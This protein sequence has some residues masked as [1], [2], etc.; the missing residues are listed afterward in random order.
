MIV[1]NVKE[2]RDFEAHTMKSLG[3]SELE[4]MNRAGYYLAKDFIKRVKPIKKSIISVF[5]G[6]GNNGGDS[7]VMAIELQKQGYKPIVYVIGD[8]P[9]A[10]DSFMHYFDIVGK[11]INISNLEELESKQFEIIESDYIIDG[12]FGIG[13]KKKITGYRSELCNFINNS[14]TIV[15]SVDIPSG[16]NPENGSILGNAIKANYTGII[17]F[18]KLGNLLDDAL[19]YHGDNLLLDIGIIQKYPINR[20]FTDINTFSID[21]PKRKN[22]SNKYTFGLGVFIGGRKSM[23]GSI[24]MSAYAGLKTG[25][26]LAVVLSDL[27]EN[28]FTQFY[29]E[30]IMQDNDGIEAKSLVKRASSVVF[31]PGISIGFENHKQ[32][33]NYLLESDIPVV[34]DASGFKYLDISKKHKNK[35][36]VL[37]PHIG[38]ISSMFG[39][40]SK[41]IHKDPLKYIEQLT[42]NNY[43]VILKGPS[44]IIANKERIRFIQA[45]NPGLATAG[46]GDVLSGNIAAYLANINVFDAMV[47]GVVTHSKAGLL[48]KKKYGE[49][50]L[51]AS[52]IIEFIHKAMK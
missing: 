9:K 40:S 42:D 46:S 23:M 21:L 34:I 14:D 33:L 3:I 24:Q 47:L 18:I 2:M 10:S 29:P 4:L 37:T 52:N 48:A 44:T 28:N 30:V 27:K 39:V 25:L 36:I 5:A 49:V 8:I 17:G 26:G 22:N 1:V 31:G 20:N 51:T 12:I 38:E 50:S 7:L 35:N 6:I 32:V 15:Y 16:I 19:D 45:K 13:L 43:N 41:D 11:I